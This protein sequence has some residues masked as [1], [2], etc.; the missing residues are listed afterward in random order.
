[1]TVFMAAGNNY[2]VGF[3]Q[4]TLFQLLNTRASTIICFI[5]N[6]IRKKKSATI[7]LALE[8]L[9]QVIKATNKSTTQDGVC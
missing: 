5:D 7:M 8:F 2:G 3:L 4:A 6:L 1:M 9:T